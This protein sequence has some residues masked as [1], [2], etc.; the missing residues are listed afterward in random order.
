[1]HRVR[2]RNRASVGATVAR[3]AYSPA[4]YLCMRIDATRLFGAEIVLGNRTSCN[5][6]FGY[7]RVSPHPGLPLF[8]M[9]TLLSM[10]LLSRASQD[11]GWLATV[12]DA[13][14]PL[15]FMGGASVA[16]INLWIQLL[17]HVLSAV[18]L[19]GI[20][21]KVGNN[22][23]APIVNFKF[24]ISV[25][26]FFMYTYLMIPV[27]LFPMEVRLLR[28]EYFNRWYSLK[29][30]YAALTFSTIPVMI[31]DDRM[32]SM[33]QQTLKNEVELLGVHDIHGENPIHLTESSQE[34]WSQLRRKNRSTEYTVSLLI[35]NI[36]E[37]LDE[38]RACVGI[39]FYLTKALDTVSAPIVLRK[40]KTLRV[41]DVALFE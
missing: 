30:Y 1:M 12:S 19:G 38:G 7:R 22:G 14:L 21:Y 13:P 18:L 24:C 8:T 4:P 33:A 6:D 32:A 27:L 34:D 39:F 36:A 37:H 17:H 40:L 25:L 2:V 11:D 3:R 29:A 9:R 5:G 23:D 41:Q 26:V 35:E 15:H 20:F 10:T 31:L 28:R 16:H